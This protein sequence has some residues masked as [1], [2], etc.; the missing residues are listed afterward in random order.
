MGDST[1]ADKCLLLQVLCLPYPVPENGILPRHAFRFA[2][3]LSQKQSCCKRKVLTRYE[4]EFYPHNPC[5]RSSF[6]SSSVFILSFQNITYQK[7]IKKMFE[8]SSLHAAQHFPKTSQC[9]PP[10]E[11]ILSWTFSFFPF[12]PNIRRSFL[13]QER[14]AGI[15][16][17]S[18]SSH[19]SGLAKHTAI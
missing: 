17:A 8:N 15:R 2:G 14:Y 12:S 16:N 9:C 7:Y 3:N 11:G 1:S 10:P 4:W 18:A 19:A 13:R 5:T 6:C